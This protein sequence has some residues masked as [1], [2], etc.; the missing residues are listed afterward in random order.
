MNIQEI[1]FEAQALPTQRQTQL[2]AQILQSAQ[3][4]INLSLESAK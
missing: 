2:T 3:E 4:K 1:L